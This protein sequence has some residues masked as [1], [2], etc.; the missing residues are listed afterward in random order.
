[1]FRTLFPVALTL[2]SLLAFSPAGADDLSSNPEH[3]LDTPAGPQHFIVH[4]Q[5]N[6]NG[7][8]EAQ[9][10]HEESRK[11]IPG[12]TSAIVL[13]GRDLDGDGKI[14]AWF[15]TDESGMVVASDTSDSQDDEWTQA[16]QIILRQNEY[17]NRWVLGILTDAILSNFTLTVGRSDSYERDLF[18]QELDARD[19]EVRVARL[20]KEDP[21][22]P[23]L[24]KY[25]ILLSDTWDQISQDIG[26]KLIKDRFIDAGID[27]GETLALFGISKGL[28]SL[29]QWQF[30]KLLASAP[31]VW[32]SGLYDALNTQV[33]EHAAQAVEALSQK[34]ADFGLDSEKIAQLKETI[35]WPAIAGAEQSIRVAL[36]ERLPAM[37]QG[38][39]ERGK[40]ASLLAKTLSP[41]KA[42]VHEAIHWSKYIAATQLVQLGIETYKRKDDLFSHNPILVKQSRNDLIH[43]VG[44]ATID[45]FAQTGVAAAD[46]NVPRRMVIAGVV[47]LVNSKAVNFFANNKV[48]DPGR[49][50]LDVGWEMTVSNVETQIDVTALQRF[51]KMATD[52]DNPKLELIG[53]AIALSD[54]AVGS[55]WYEKESSKYYVDKAAGTPM[56]KWIPSWIPIF[57]EKQ[58]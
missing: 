23:D 6:S 8:I 54:D 25:D 38:L 51:E 13:Y 48:S 34:A 56:F 58:E 7:E 18:Q 30:P 53:Y 36:T 27:A 22:N 14:D 31:G 47:A 3:I 37:I 42:G 1:M 40:I 35:R 26:S 45:T 44:F 28:G 11:L 15:Y 46:S 39:N 43:D 52:T 19:L 57:G 29:I 50:T 24:L 9:I 5:T 33:R 41:V 20:A 55:Y 2:I 10:E 21:K 49:T 12:Q 32:A 17:K 4:R 16:S